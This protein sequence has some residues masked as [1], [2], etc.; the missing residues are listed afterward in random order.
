MT[1]SILVPVYK[2]EPYIRECAESLFSQTYGDIEYIFCDDCT[3]DKSIDVLCEVMADYPERKVRIIR[4][5]RNMGIGGTRAHLLSEVT[6]DGF[7]FVDSDDKIPQDAVEVLV[8]RME[9]TGA[10][11]IDAGYSEYA[12]GETGEAVMP[13]HD[14]GDHY[15][16]KVLVNNMVSL[17]LWGRL[18]KT[19]VI[20][21]VPRLFEQGID[22]AED[23]SATCRLMAVATRTWTDKVVYY[24]RTDNMTSYSNNISEKNVL[25]YFRA[26]GRVLCFYADRGKL[27]LALE[28][29]MLS[30]YRQCRRSDIPL[31][32]ADATIGYKPLHP[33]ARMVFALLRATSLPLAIGDYLYRLLRACAI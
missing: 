27:P 7:I 18:Y 28:V 5:Q 3:P 32:K 6:T 23:Y 9:E 1:I 33:A 26:C 29:G 22:F 12:N 15:L 25:S 10:D 30:A 19:E 31:H 16:R 24:Y 21:R 4:N 20:R 13:C 14:V 11:I 8:R 17:R 2:V